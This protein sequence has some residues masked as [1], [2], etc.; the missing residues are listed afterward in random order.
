VHVLK[1]QEGKTAWQQ[2]WY[3]TSTPS[4]KWER[5]PLNI[6]CGSLA[7][8]ASTRGLE[9]QNLQRNGL[10]DAHRQIAG[11]QVVRPTPPPNSHSYS[12]RDEARV[13]SGVCNSQPTDPQT[14]SDSIPEPTVVNSDEL[15]DEILADG[16]VSETR[17]DHSALFNYEVSLLVTP[18]IARPL[19][20][21][22]LTYSLSLARTRL[23]RYCCVRRKSYD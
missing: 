15:I 14:R 20:T 12:T 22:L 4:T 18:L 2:C 3:E 7:K 21:T 10:L 9:S 8:D 19:S 16:Q 11:N 13:S 1:A 17:E 6:F 5:A 23:Y